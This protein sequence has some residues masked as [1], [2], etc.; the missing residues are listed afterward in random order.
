MA[1]AAQDELR[2]PVLKPE[3]HKKIVTLYTDL[4]KQGRLTYDPTLRPSD[5]LV[6]AFAEG[7]LQDFDGLLARHG[8]TPQ[9]FT[10][11]LL[12]PVIS[13]YGRELGRYGW[14]ARLLGK[15]APE[16]KA[17]GAE[18][19]RL[20]LDLDEGLAVHHWWRRL[21]HVRRGMLVTQLSTAMRNFETQVG[22][23]GLDVLQAPLDAGLQGLTGKPQSVH[24]LDGWED[25]LTVFSRQQPKVIDAVLGAFPRQKDRLLMTYSSDLMTK[26]KAAGLSLPGWAQQADAILSQ[27]ES[28]V[29]VLNT[30]NRAQE[31]FIRRGV[32]QATLDR[33]VAKQGQ[34]LTQ[35]IAQNQAGTIPRDLI[36]QAV[37]HALKVTFAEQ[38]AYGS[39]GANFIKLVNQVPGLTFAI[40]F[41]RFLVNSAKFLFEYNPTGF[42][43]YLAPAER[44]AF[45]KGDTATMSKAILGTM[46]LGAAWQVRNSEVAGERWY[47]AKMPDGKTID[48]RPF[49]PFASYLFIADTVK[50]LQEGRLSKLDWR[51]ML[52]GLLSTNLRAGTGLYVVEQAIQGLT[53]SDSWDKLVR[54]L[55]E[56][57]GEV[58]GGFFTPL[59]QLVDVLGEFDEGYR[60]VR[61]R[62]AE[63][64]WGPIKAQIP[65]VAKDV[66]EAELPTRA[67]PLR[68]VHPL[69]KQLTGF[70]VTEPKNAVEAELDRL[71]FRSYELLRPTGEY[72]YDTRRALLMGPVVERALTPLVHSDVYRSWSDAEKAFVL[73]ERLKAIRHA[74][75]PLA[76]AMGSL[77]ERQARRLHRQPVRK[78]RVIEERRAAPSSGS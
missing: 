17:L 76:D 52:T 67:G 48:L 13:M 58:T 46:L 12:Q 49:N 63:P 78:Q 10:D 24:P 25:L 59:H 72:E 19:K 5:Q 4:V 65:V 50:R 14:V 27:A 30:V 73:A 77:E 21:D 29:N 51:D 15:Q 9:E 56:F 35:M 57:G 75:T 47:E 40:P 8:M 39:L 66:P 43:K 26:A 7:K 74:I 62:R 71:G 60:V 16:I 37:D 44:A 38:P 28:L 3:I 68:R 33:L 64:F 41:P 11:D 42:L 53:R 55:Q 6:A 36:E 18:L 45:A 69:L 54:H 20:G 2:T 61:D 32:F 1:A 22:R 23:L 31:F 34:N 70:Q